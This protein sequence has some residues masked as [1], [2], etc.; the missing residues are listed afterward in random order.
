MDALHILLI[1]LGSLAFGLVRVLA[2]P[3][4]NGSL[5]RWIT[6]RGP[7]QFRPAHMVGR[8]L[9]P[10][11][12]R[13]VTSLPAEVRY[14]APLALCAAVG[15][16][17]GLALPSGASTPPAPATA[18]HTA[19]QPLEEDDPGWCRTSPDADPT[20]ECAG[21]VQYDD[22]H[23]DVSLVDPARTPIAPIDPVADGRFT[24]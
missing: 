14:G 15:L 2:E 17:I 19:V 4:M 6:R 13:A 7:L 12:L 22:P 10:A 5:F 9:L 1:T 8:P 3:W 20:G 16:A 18:P 24:Q 21:I 11:R 23:V